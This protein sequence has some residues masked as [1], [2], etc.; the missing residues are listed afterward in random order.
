MVCS[1]L[2][3]IQAKYNE[4]I[5]SNYMDEVLK[6]G[7]EEASSIAKVTLQR[8]KDAVGLLKTR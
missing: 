3:N 2:E 1:T 6:K 8:V 4:Y 7:A 5:N